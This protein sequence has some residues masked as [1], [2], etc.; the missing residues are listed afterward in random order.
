MSFVGYACSRCGG[1]F[2]PEQATYRCPKGCE[3]LDVVLDF[4]A[5]QKQDISQSRDPSL[6]RYAPLL[7]VEVP[8]DEAGPLR[9]VGGTPL[10]AAP[11]GAARLGLGQLWLKDEGRMPTGSLKDRA[12]AVVV[13]RAKA[14][15]APRVITA[16]TGNAGVALAAMAPCAGV[17]AIIVVPETA[18]AGKLAQLAIFGARVVLVK[19][20]YDDAF[21]VSDAAA[22]ELGWY[23]RNTAHNP[24]TVEGK[25]TV[26]FEI[27]EQLSWRAPEWVVV[28]VGDGNILVGVHKGFRELVEIGFIDRM[29]KILGVQAEGSSPI[30]RAFEAGTDVIE[31]VVTHTLADSIAAGKPADGPRALRAVRDTEGAFVIVSDDEILAAI[32]ALGADAAV[33]AEPAAAA[34]YAGLERARV[35]G[36]VPAGAEVVTL[37]TGN[38]LKDVAAATRAARHVAPV[39][40]PTLDALRA[41]LGV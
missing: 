21:E 12:S 41:A 4:S 34:A 6:W 13:Q 9:G 8:P 1:R 40:D 20:S 11:R 17:E 38:G 33:F 25:K 36:I 15:G 22:R 5:A 31:P 2:T 18:P 19:G 3:N 10:Y 30:A 39:I 23:C 27:A 37:V 35:G 24:F 26:A 14:I 7:P 29:P 16:S 28:S 32:A